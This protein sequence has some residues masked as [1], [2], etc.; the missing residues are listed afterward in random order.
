MVVEVV[1]VVKVV[2]VS[3]LE[4]LLGSCCQSSQSCC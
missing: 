2:T 1:G 3:V 4:R